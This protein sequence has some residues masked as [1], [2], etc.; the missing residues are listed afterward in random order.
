MFILSPGFLNFGPDPVTP[1][2]F[3]NFAPNS[4]DPRPIIPQESEPTASHTFNQPP[5]AILE[6]LPP[7]GSQLID[8]T[9]T[10]FPEPI[11]EVTT[12]P[13]T[14]DISLQG[15]TDIV[16]GGEVAEEPS[17]DLIFQIATLPSPVYSN[18][19]YTAPPPAAP[20]LAPF[21]NA[22]VPNVDLVFEKAT[23]PVTTEDADIQST[24]PDFTTTSE[25][26]FTDP[27]T[28]KIPLTTDIQTEASTINIP[29][30]KPSIAKQDKK[31]N[32]G[33]GRKI[34][35]VTGDISL[36][37]IDI[38]Q[39]P[40]VQQ[41]V[42]EVTPPPSLAIAG[43][44]FNLQ[45]APSA[46]QLSVTNNNADTHS[47]NF[48]SNITR[49][50][51]LPQIRLSHTRISKTVN[52]PISIS[53]RTQVRTDKNGNLRVNR[54]QRIGNKVVNA[55]NRGRG[56]GNA[57][58]RVGKIVENSKSQNGKSQNSNIGKKHTNNGPSVPGQNITQVPVQKRTNKNHKNAKQQHTGQSSST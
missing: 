43:F 9:T 48:S 33:K 1:P 35:P 56:A 28:T 23:L 42:I 16:T 45:V 11:A 34:P 41:Q 49:N 5:P 19:V 13:T 18:L 24:T 8:A 44:P 39:V 31:K 58:I 12:F 26:I 36:P 54:Q 40:V 53:I 32:G 10:T 29:V 21:P 14:T 30:P 20:I 15:P 52:R 3:P 57:R 38:A 27:T 50:Y 46:Q 37:I 4:V 6:L 7:F 47:I 2:V 17:E 55:G 22:E 25:P 51:S